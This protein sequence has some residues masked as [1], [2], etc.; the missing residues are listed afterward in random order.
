[1][2]HASSDQNTT[3]EIPFH[4]YFFYFTIRSLSW[5]FGSFWSKCRHLLLRYRLSRRCWMNTATLN[6]F[7]TSGLSYFKTVQKTCFLYSEFDFTELKL[8]RNESPSVKGSQQLLMKLMMLV[9]S[10]TSFITRWG[11]S[12]D[13]SSFR[14]NP[15]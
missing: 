9:R 12:R 3:H 6:N 11:H 7:I 15:T 14:F 13:T 5:N 2:K 1:M 8:Y 10:F 4:S